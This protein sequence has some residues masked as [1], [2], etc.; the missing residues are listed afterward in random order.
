MADAELSAEQAR[1]DEA[2]EH[3]DAM[4][5]KVLEL[6]KQPLPEKEWEVALQRR[7]FLLT[8]TGRALCFGRIDHDDDTTFYV[9]R[10]H[11]EDGN[12]DPVIIEWRT[13]AAVPFYRA[14]VPEPLGL[15]R[16]RQFVVDHR[17]ILSM[18]D[19]QFGPDAP[20]G[21]VPRVRGRDALL[22]ELDRARGGEMLDIVATIQGE[23]D[24]VIRSP[25]E[26]VLFVQGGPGTGK[27]AVGLHRAAFL[28]YG[29]EA[30]AR[31]GVLV[32]GPNRIFLRYIAAVLPSLG[33]EAVVQTTLRDL[34][35]SA[36]VTATDAPEVERI[37]GDLAMAEHLA[38]ALAARRRPLEVDLVVSFGSTRLVLPAAEVNDAVAGLASRRLAFNQGRSALRDQLLRRFHERYTEVVGG[39]LNAAEFPELA[40]A[41]R[42][43]R[44]FTAAIN[45]VW[46]A[47][48]AATLVRGV[49]RDQLGLKAR[50]T[51]S[52]ADI[53]L[54]DEATAL[55]EGRG[56][57]YGHVV[58]DEAQDLSP[59]QIRML[60][61]R[62]PAGSMTVLGD[63]A[64]GSS[65]WAPDRWDEVAA[66][67]PTPRG[68][69]TV[70]LT[71]G[72]RAPAQV[73][74]LAA[75]LLP[76]I[77][78]Q[79]KPTESVRR[80]RFEPRIVAAADVVAAAGSEAAT[81]AGEFASVG[82]ITPVS[83]LAAVEE[84]LAGA[85]VDWADAAAG[86]LD[87]RVSVLTGVAAK[88]LEFDAV[89]VVE[90]A[91]LVEDAAR[92][93]RLLYIALT[94]PTQQLTVVHS[95]PLPF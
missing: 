21:E 30:L 51:W 27:T 8:D 83:L 32:V 93:L 48:N 31:D 73:L 23:Q 64:Q 29:N 70:E 4:R 79:V 75:R 71:L 19:D 57:T 80:G 24:E 74:D 72:Y 28:L 90:P 78:P 50:R 61:R 77:A 49:L 52:D 81:L 58:V 5:A 35:P 13:P 16:R 12:S 2:Y 59:M 67:L 1:L 20:D 86:G 6:L 36:A 25:Q 60:A 43:D 22:L 69:R 7:A 47:V 45:R 37:K 17:T 87:H 85:G 56:R 68:H 9:G 95:R 62:C 10:R 46:P 55:L 84:A 38:A 40:A 44:A 26:G 65:V 11:V 33:E 15:R 39:R 18:A 63:L 53:A 76:H 89:L 92:G 82:V 91:A 41:V 14:T 3:L 54:L 94:R 42:R 88:G 66:L 34:V